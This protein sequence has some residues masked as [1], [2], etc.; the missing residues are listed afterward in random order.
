MNGIDD[1]PASGI[2]QKITRDGNEFTVVSKEGV[3]N[4]YGTGN[5]NLNNYKMY[6]KQVED[7]CGNTIDYDYYVDSGYLYL[8]SIRYTGHISGEPGNYEI[9]FDSEGRDDR[10]IDCRGK[11]TSK[12]ALRLKDIIIK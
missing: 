7:P 3:I 1:V 9:E 2:L 4:R 5:S 12:L 6:I 11:F 8:S 10:L